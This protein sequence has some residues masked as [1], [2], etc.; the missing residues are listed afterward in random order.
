MNIWLKGGGR[1]ACFCGDA[2]HHP[3]QCADP[4]LCCSSDFDSPQGIVS[5][6]TMLETCADTDTLLMTGHFLEPTAGRVVS[7]GDAFRFRFV[8]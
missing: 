2:I 6:R 4:T 5:R 8:D 1:R 3:I 7:N